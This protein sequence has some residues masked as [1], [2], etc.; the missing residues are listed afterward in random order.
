MKK[1]LVLS[2]FFLLIVSSLISVTSASS[3][4]G[5]EIGTIQFEIFPDIKSQAATTV[6]ELEVENREKFD[7]MLPLALTISTL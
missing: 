1:L 4:K 6:Q 2:I 7:K 3:A 5:P